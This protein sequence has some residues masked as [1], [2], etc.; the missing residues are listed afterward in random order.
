MTVRVLFLSEGTSD[1]GLV[2]HVEGIAADLG[3]PVTVSAP[4]LRWLRLPAGHSV[5]DKLRTTR[6]LGGAY[7]LAVIQRDADRGAPEVRRTEIADAVGDV[8]PGLAHVP[9][10]P[11][12]MLE[13][14]L[15][16]DEQAIREVA[17]NP[18][19]RLPLDLPTAASAERVA[20][21]KQRLKDTIATASGCKGR[22]LAELNQRFPK[23]RHRLL[24]LLDRHGPVSEVTSWRTFVA[25]LSTA[26]RTV[27]PGGSM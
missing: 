18:R 3:V 20:D 14:W 26:L 7:D 15:L 11:V 23:N 1:Q 13:A 21:P 9:V 5:T 27:V 19:G 10:V 16:L 4:D 8:W 24:D 12:R 22:R 2:S 25:E 17:G 6:D